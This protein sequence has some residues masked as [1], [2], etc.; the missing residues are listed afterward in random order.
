MTNHKDTIVE[1]SANFS[2]D[3]LNLS[4]VSNKTETINVSKHPNSLIYPQKVQ[5]R[6]MIKFQIT[7]LRILVTN[8]KN[9]NFI[10]ILNKWMLLLFIQNQKIIMMIQNYRPGDKV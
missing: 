1:P 7:F 6:V 8:V 4:N 2:F 5:S 9:L 3:L 10:L